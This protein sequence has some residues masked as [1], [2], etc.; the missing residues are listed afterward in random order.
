MRFGLAAFLLF[1]LSHVR[2]DDAFEKDV[3][4]LLVERCLSCHGGAKT[5]GGKFCMEC[6]GTL[7]AKKAC[8][9]CGHEAEGSPKFCPEC[10][11]KY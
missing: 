10:G 11:G 1:G 2:A 7:Q 6:G 4:P 9:Q 5:Q 8:G 3:R